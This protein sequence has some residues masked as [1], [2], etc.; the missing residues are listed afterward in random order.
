VERLSAR[1]LA[2]P[3]YEDV[4]DLPDLLDAL[5]ISVD[6]SLTDVVH[7]VLKVLGALDVV[8]RWCML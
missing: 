3:R 1:F 2:H 4:L 5:A 6:P 7:L 8:T